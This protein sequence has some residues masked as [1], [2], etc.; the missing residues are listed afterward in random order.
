MPSKED[1]EQADLDALIAEQQANLPDW[2]KQ[3]QEREKS[4]RVKAL[5]PIK[6]RVVKSKRIWSRYE[7]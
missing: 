1:K 5:K 6:A 4:G 3:Q 7:L 2:W